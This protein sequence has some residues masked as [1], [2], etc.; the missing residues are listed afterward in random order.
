MFQF[1]H[2]LRRQL[3]MERNEVDLIEVPDFKDFYYHYS[4]HHRNE[5]HEYSVIGISKDGRVLDLVTKK[6]YNPFDHNGRPRSF[7]YIHTDDK[8][9]AWLSIPRSLAFTFI[10]KPLKYKDKTTIELN[11]KHLDYNLYNNSLDNLEWTD[12]CSLPENWYDYNESL[13]DIYDLRDN[14]VREVIPTYRVLEFIKFIAEKDLDVL[15]LHRYMITHPEGIKVGDFLIHFS[16]DN[17]DWDKIKFEHT[18]K[19]L[20]DYMQN[21]AIMENIITHEEKRFD[22]LYDAAMFLDINPDKLKQHLNNGQNCKYRYGLWILNE[23]SE[24]AMPFHDLNSNSVCPTADSKSVF[25]FDKINDDNFLFLH[26][27]D[28]INKYK[29][30]NVDEAIYYLRQDRRY[31]TKYGTITFL[32]DN[33]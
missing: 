25:Y 16:D 30:I 14:K 19:R 21:G 6:I 11:V 23:Y 10:G 15:M 26:I 7:V 12:D 17:I 32:E 24:D 31:E 3:V 27:Y 13:F 20:T 2:E 9:M 1:F 8:V 28:L 18:V 5:S 4:E 33:C 29:N 22:S